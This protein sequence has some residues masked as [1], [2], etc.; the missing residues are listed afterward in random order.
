MK[1]LNSLIFLID[2]YDLMFTRSISIPL[3]MMKSSHFID[4]TSNTFLNSSSI[5]I[6]QLK[7]I[8]MLHL[9]AQ[10]FDFPN[11]S[12]LTSSIK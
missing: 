7:A 10:L 9:Q 8:S 1:T 6:L 11:Y 5:K 3:L 2:Q 12:Y 4:E